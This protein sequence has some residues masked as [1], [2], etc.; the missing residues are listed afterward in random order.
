MVEGGPG[1][2]VMALGGLTGSYAELE[3]WIP[4]PIRAP[5]PKC[6]AIPVL[7]ITKHPA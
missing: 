1:F 2:E 6:A 3:E 5:S 4:T 7:I